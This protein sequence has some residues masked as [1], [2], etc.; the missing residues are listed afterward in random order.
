MQTDP[1]ATLLEIQAQRAPLRLLLIPFLLALAAF[2]STWGA[3]F[4]YDDIELI[5]TNPAMS[6]WAT[7]AR[8]FQEPFWSLAPFQQNYAGYYRP[9]SATAFVILHKISGGKPWS[10]HLAST[11]IH[12]LSALLVVRLALGI[13]LKRGAAL[14]AGI[15][16][17]LS[18]A[19]VEA[20]AWVSALPDLLATCFSLL[21]LNAFL[22]GRLAWALPALLLAM[23]S[24]E[25]AYATWLILLGISALGSR[26]LPLARRLYALPSLLLIG[27]LVYG[28]RFLVFDG[29]AAGFDMQLTFAQLEPMHER[30]LSFSLIA[31][32]LVFLIAPLGSRPFRPLRLDEGASE[33]APLAILGALLALAALIYWLLR[34]RRSPLIL[35]GFALLFGGLAP[36][37]NTNSI[38]RFP[39]EERFTYLASTGFALLIGAALFRLAKSSRQRKQA[40]AGAGVALALGLTWAAV[41][42]PPL[43]RVTP[44]WADHEGFARW[45]TEVSPETMTPWILAGQATLQRAQGLPQN[46]QARIAAAEEAF[47]FFERSLK[48]NPDE[49][50]VA[51]HE[52]ETGNVGLGDALF[53][54]GDVNVAQQIYEETL[55]GYP[56]SQAAHLGLSSVLLFKADV[57]NQSSARLE[58][59][60]QRALARAE[61]LQLAET[62]R[63]HADQ[64]TRGNRELGAFYHN[65]SV[66]N[67]WIGMIRDKR[68]LETAE[69]DA[70]RSIQLDPRNYAFVLH[71]AEVQYIRE[72]LPEMLKTLE[73]YL[74]ADPNTPHR[75][76]VES[77]IAAMR[78]QG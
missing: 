3:G 48:I 20:V 19:H 74:V 55:K 2:A 64:A 43:V 4:V 33:L 5:E 69:A 71:L 18:G 63:V 40:S 24:K 25:S 7:V 8:S 73:A 28:L 50:L 60:E 9:V 70:S 15:A 22:R 36:V 6:E 41:N 47:D 62:A 49:V 75:E 66:A 57:T 76:E 72:R 38:G 26:Q 45:A 37:L 32:Y 14:L 31:R 21:A 58:D 23:L 56:Y 1:S 16:F 12:A 53:V 35:L 65:R 29:A 34:G 61:I 52:R 59:P 51:G 77:S 39:F 27:G 30:A 44:R 13:G 54:A 68:V 46:S 17:A 10:F 67:Y 42:L 78:G 11:L